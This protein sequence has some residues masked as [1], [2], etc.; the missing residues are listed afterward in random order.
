MNELHAGGLKILIFSHRRL[1]KILF[2]YR[3]DVILE[4][5]KYFGNS[6]WSGVWRY[7]P[8]VS[9]RETRFQFGS[10]AF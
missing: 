6:L 7:F 3:L 2:Q 8:L 1:E 9:P 10:N 5:I 4:V